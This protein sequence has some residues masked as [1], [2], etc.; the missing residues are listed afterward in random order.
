MEIVEKLGFST[1]KPGIT[2]SCNGKSRV[3]NREIVEISGLR[4]ELRQAMDRFCFFGFLPKKFPFEK[5]V[6]VF[7]GAGR[8][9]PENLCENATKRFG[10]SFRAVWKYW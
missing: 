4:K 5:V 1:A 10:V 9:L 7:G 8:P 2:K 6:A 3:R